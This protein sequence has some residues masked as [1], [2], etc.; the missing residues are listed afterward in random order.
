MDSG[1][2]TGFESYRP[3]PPESNR[4]ARVV[5]VIIKKNTIKTT[6]REFMP[7]STF[8]N[9]PQFFYDNNSLSCTF[10]RVLFENYLKS[11]VALLYKLQDSLMSPI[12]PSLPSCS[13]LGTD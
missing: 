6:S 13:S 5:R 8:F 10:A 9:T 4:A 3:Q 2:K 1:R 11:E 12:S 7:S